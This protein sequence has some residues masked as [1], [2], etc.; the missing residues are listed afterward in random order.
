MAY[1]TA[2]ELRTQMDKTGTAGSG[3]DVNLTI[4]LDGVSQAID[5]YFNR[6]DDWFVALAV[7]AARLFPG[8]GKA[9]Q[10]IDECVEISAV[11]VK[12]SPSDSSYTAWAATDYIK[13][14]GDPRFPDF[15]GL[16]YT[17]IMIDPNGDYSVFTSGLYG[18]LHGFRPSG[19]LGR[20]IPTVQ[21]TAKWG[22][23]VTCPPVIKQAT[24]ALA[25]RW[26]KQGQ[27]AWADTLASADF[28]GLIYQKMNSDIRLML[29][30]TRFHKPALGVR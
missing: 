13:F 15:N 26:F 21:V 30:N 6:P 11:A 7:A 20:A 25:A 12:S 3:S 8:S 10:I 4:V 18:G 23:A 28:G 17:G 27:G 22:Y 29:E 16:P 1:A 14:T 5:R 19:N 9:Y 2:D 24:L